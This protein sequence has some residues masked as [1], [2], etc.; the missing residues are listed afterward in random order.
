[1]LAVPSLDEA[2]RIAGALG[3]AGLPRREGQWWDNARGLPG[4]TWPKR[5]HG[6]ADPGRP[7]NLHVR[8]TGT[9]GWRFALLMRD[10]LRADHEA[11]RGY[12]DAKRAWQAEHTDVDSYAD[13]KEPWFD[14]EAAAAEE[15]AQRTGWQPA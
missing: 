13:A 5:L 8:V 10:H 6:S 3:A 2:D 7:V 4:Q 12:A 9:P 1:M 15:W 11:M 14:G